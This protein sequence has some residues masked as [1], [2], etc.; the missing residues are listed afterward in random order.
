M[1]WDLPAL[2]LCDKADIKGESEMCLLKYIFALKQTE[3][4]QNQLTFQIWIL[5]L[6]TVVVKMKYWFP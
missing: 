5:D 2:S 6:Q 4:N 3:L 1:A